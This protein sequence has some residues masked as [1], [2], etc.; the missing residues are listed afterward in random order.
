METFVGANQ[1]L[2]ELFTIAEDVLGYVDNDDVQVTKVIKEELENTRCTTSMTVDNRMKVWD[3]SEFSYKLV[4]SQRQVV[5]GPVWGDGV[6][7]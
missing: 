3:T 1:L 4:C 5:V 6:V 2:V 7:Y